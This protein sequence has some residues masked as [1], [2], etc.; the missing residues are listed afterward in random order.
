MLAPIMK[1]T[2]FLILLATLM[3]SCDSTGDTGSEYADELDS[4]DEATRIDCGCW[5][6]DYGYSS[7]SACIADIARGP[8]SASE[9]ACVQEAGTN[10]VPLEPAYKCLADAQEAR[11]A[12]FR[13]VQ[14]GSASAWDACEDDFDVE[15]E[16]C[17]NLPCGNGDTATQ[18]RGYQ[19]SFE[20][21]VRLSCL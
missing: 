21:E 19:T 13:S 8:L 16:R 14:C 2:L 20:N 15:R 11:V 17:R 18:C 10:Y 5:F 1:K 4:R 9:R 3:A 7:A 12:C 6:D